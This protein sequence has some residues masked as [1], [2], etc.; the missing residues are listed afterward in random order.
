VATV[1]KINIIII[2]KTINVAQL[3]CGHQSK[4]LVFCGQLTA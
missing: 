4:E 2:M 1:K 3:L